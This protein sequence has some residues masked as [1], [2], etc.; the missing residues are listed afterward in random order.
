M[1]KKCSDYDANKT[2]AGYGLTGERV[3]FLLHECRAGKYTDLVRQAAQ[4]A[5]PCIAKWIITSIA[6]GKSLHDMEIRWELGEAEIMP[7]CRNSFYAYRKHALA[8]LNKMLSE[9]EV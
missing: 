5:E 1:R 7:C 3:K 8:I 4:Q 6:D 2:Y 9:R